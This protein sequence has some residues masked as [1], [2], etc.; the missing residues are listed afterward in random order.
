MC[1]EGVP[2]ILHVVLYSKQI[3]NLLMQ[4]EYSHAREL[5]CAA[6]HMLENKSSSFSFVLKNYEARSLFDESFH[7]AERRNAL[8]AKAEAIYREGHGAGKYALNNDLGDVCLAKGDYENAAGIL[9]QSLERAEKSG[10]VFNIFAIRTSLA[11][12]YLRSG[13]NKNAI[14]EAAEIEKLAVR[15]KQGRWRVYARRLMALAYYNQRDFKR[16]LECDGHCLAAAMAMDGGPEKDDIIKN[17]YV[18]RGHS[19][20]ELKKYSSAALNFEAA[21]KAGADGALLMSAQEG[22][23]EVYY[24]TKKY[25]LAMECFDKAEKLLVA[26]PSGVAEAYKDKIAE[27]KVQAARK[28]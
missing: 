9:R 10:H 11:E 6:G 20:K 21:I 27:L 8:L 15:I 18:R 28:I 16:E 12:A 13:D 23:G 26:M 5:I 19:F 17:L 25:K 3:K 4:R 14:K 24:F 7:K 2:R 1:L 22:L